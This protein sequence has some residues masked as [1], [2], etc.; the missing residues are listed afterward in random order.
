MR[1]EA[2][3]VNVLVSRSHLRGS[4][5]PDSLGE[6]NRLSMGYDAGA[7]RYACT[8]K[9]GVLW[10]AGREAGVPSACCLGCSRSSSPIHR[11][12][13]RGRRGSFF[14]R[15]TF[16][17]TARSFSRAVVSLPTRTSTSTCS[18]RIRG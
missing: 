13:R 17:P 6:T 15:P 9:G 2:H 16:S 3:Y 14:S 5:C 7:S 1:Q 11:L 4:V 10:E 12:R 8:V 18:A